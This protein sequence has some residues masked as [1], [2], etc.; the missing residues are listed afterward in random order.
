MGDE[1]GLLKLDNFFY[2]NDSHYVTIGFDI[3]DDIPLLN[4]SAFLFLNKVL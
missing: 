1:G 2:I 3:V 4:N